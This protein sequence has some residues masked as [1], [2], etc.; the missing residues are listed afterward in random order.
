MGRAR[1]QSAHGSDVR[2][3]LFVVSCP[4]KP[5]SILFRAPRRLMF[6]GVLYTGLAMKKEEERGKKK[7][8]ERKEKESEQYKE[9]EERKLCQD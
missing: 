2:V 3:S 4:S 8:E 1:K 5:A 7:R 6:I 9:C